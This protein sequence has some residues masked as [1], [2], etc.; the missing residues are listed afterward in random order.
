[1]QEVHILQATLLAFLSPFP[2]FTLINY[3]Y[4]SSKPEH[5]FGERFVDMKRLGPI[6]QALK[7]RSSRR[8]LEI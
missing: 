3:Y 7:S 5:W 2:L 4:V 8:G 1:M 6:L